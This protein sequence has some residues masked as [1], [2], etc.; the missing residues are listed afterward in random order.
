MKFTT[1]IRG[2]FS[3]FG[4]KMV[5][6][7][8]DLVKP[9]VEMNKNAL[10]C[11]KL[12]KMSHTIYKILLGFVLLAF[13]FCALRA[14]DEKKSSAPVQKAATRVSKELSAPTPKE[15][16]LAEDYVRLAKELTNKKEYAKAEVYW[17]KA[18]DLYNKLNLKEKAAEITREL[19]KL[20]E[21]Q[22]NTNNAVKLYETAELNSLKSN[23][24]ELNRNDADRL[25]N[26][27]NPQ[28]QSDYIE[29]NI[30]L[31]QKEDIYSEEEVAQAYTQMADVKMK[32]NEFPA[33]LENYETALKNVPAKAQ[34]ALS[35]QRKIA[36]VYLNE[37]QPEKGI[38]TLL[39]VYRLA[40]SENNTM[41]AAKS[42]E[43]LTREYHKQGKD[44]KAMV[45][46]Q[47]FLYNLE[48]LIRADSSLIDVKIFQSTE[49]KI[50]QLEKEKSLQEALIGKKN[51]LNRVLI[52]SMVLMAAFLFLLGR[53]LRSIKIRN[54]KIALQSL[55]REMN[56]HFIFN[57][58][59]SVNQYIAQNDEVAANKYL[60]SYSRL[61]RNTMENSGK[62]FIRLDREIALL[63]EYLEL[64]HLRFGDKFS[65]EI[66][67][68]KTVETETLYVPGMLIQPCLENAIWHGLRYKDDT[69][70][71]KLSVALSGKT[72]CI[73]VDDNG[74]GLSKSEALKTANQKMHRSRGL[75]NINERI[76]LLCEIYKLAIQLQIEEKPLSESGVKATITLPLIH[77]IKS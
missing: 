4:L 1:K 61:M 31:L 40:L 8:F 36:E 39:E 70:L 23:A 15:E 58:L 35:I 25:K 68:D 10:L 16:T 65:Y 37:Q 69:G 6:P 44:K 51:S 22:G 56:P 64:E 28:V 43:Q 13:S 72:L 12:V 60:A 74:I 50:I 46:Y 19:A 20:Q 11:R 53:A 29:K 52:W 54:K 7:R 76:K 75:N 59:N 57:S 45:L 26:A 21:A 5:K 63:N 49:E 55:R 34:E 77:N 30:Q 14:Q 66:I 67:I 71:L 38:N 17:N 62:D 41:E 33:A 48:Q 18:R 24:K 9:V 47:E 42:L 32:M 27:D 3:V 73:T 2:N